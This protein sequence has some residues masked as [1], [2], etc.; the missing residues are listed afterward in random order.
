MLIDAGNIAPG[1]VASM[2]GRE[3]RDEDEKQTVVK[4]TPGNPDI[5][6]QKLRDARESA[7]VQLQDMYDSMK[8]RV[9]K[10]EDLTVF[11]AGGYYP[12]DEFSIPDRCRAL[13]DKPSNR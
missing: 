1:Y 13:P 4:D 8:A 5:E 3:G 7:K 6:W 12:Q 2:L 11:V 10:N 9:G